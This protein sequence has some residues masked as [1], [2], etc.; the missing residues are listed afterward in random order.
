M[1]TSAD[2]N[3]TFECTDEMIQDTLPKGSV[4]DNIRLVTIKGGSIYERL[5][6][7]VDFTFDFTDVEP[8]IHPQ[9]TV[10]FVL[11][12]KEGFKGSLISSCMRMV[13]METCLDD[14]V[15][16]A[17]ELKSV[18]DNICF[19]KNDG[20]ER[21]IIDYHYSILNKKIVIVLRHPEDYKGMLVESFNREYPFKL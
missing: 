11:R 12:Y 10:K 21:V 18:I 2:K 20:L 5:C 14:Q 3:H 13:E 7:F 17:I 19:D 8:K 16:T 4:I 1:N 6:L 9:R 15:D